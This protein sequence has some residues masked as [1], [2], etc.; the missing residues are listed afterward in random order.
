MEGKV[1][2]RFTILELDLVVEEVAWRDGPLA[3]H[4]RTI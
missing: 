2:S 4:R 3:G 1:R